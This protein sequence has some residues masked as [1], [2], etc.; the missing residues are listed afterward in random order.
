MFGIGSQ[1]FSRCGEEN[2]TLQ[3]N[4]ISACLFGT[5]TLGTWLNF[6]RFVSF[7]VKQKW[8]PGFLSSN[9]LTVRKLFYLSCKEADLSELSMNCGCVFEPESPTVL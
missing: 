4:L 8:F 2:T 7:S 3:H 9:N 1:D 5:G 6:A